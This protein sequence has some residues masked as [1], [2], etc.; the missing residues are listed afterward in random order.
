[1]ALIIHYFNKAN[2]NSVESNMLPN[3]K[4]Y[5]RQLA[6]TSETNQFL[7]PWGGICLR[8]CDDDG[9]FLKF[10]S[11]CDY[12]PLGQRMWLHLHILLFRDNVSL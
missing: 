12:K 3:L 6:T 1:M 10:K 9:D 2:P 11:I 8:N 5:L 7:M 4:N